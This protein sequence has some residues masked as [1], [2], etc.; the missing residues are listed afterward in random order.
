MK[1]LDQ[2]IYLEGNSHQRKVMPT[3]VER[4]HEL[5]SRGY[6]KSDKIN[7]FKL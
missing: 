1:S 2:Y 5:L 4:S 6:W 3:Y 7:S